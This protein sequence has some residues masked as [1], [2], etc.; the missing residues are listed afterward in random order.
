MQDERDDLTLPMAMQRTI[1]ARHGRAGQEWLDDLPHRVNELERRWGVRI[2]P[3]FGY[4]SVNFVAPGTRTDGTPVVLKVSFNGAE[5]IPEM[6]TLRLA[7]GEGMVRLLEEDPGGHAFLMERAVPGDLLFDHPDDEAAT[8]IAARVMAASWRHAPSSHPFPTVADWGD[9]FQRMRE[10][11]QGG[12]GPLPAEITS[13]AERLF[14]E[15]VAT[16]STPIVLHGDLHHF[17]ILRST[18]RWVAI[19]PK[20]VLGDPAYEIGALMRNRLPDLDDAARARA[21]LLRRI[22]VV[23]DETGLDPE[24]MRRWTIAQALL[25]AWWTIEDAGDIAD[26]QDVIQVAGLLLTDAD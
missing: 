17:N 21:L 16:S 10:R 6:A 1:V 13:R 24:R 11:Y 5:L 18:D 2:G 9:G 14:D 3:R 23:A 20:G 25:S 22:W 7:G 8:R 26:A 4:P 15:L 19:D 12:T